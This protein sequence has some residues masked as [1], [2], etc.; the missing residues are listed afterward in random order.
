MVS[1]MHQLIARFPSSFSV[2]QC[3]ERTGNMH[4]FCGPDYGPN[5]TT[6]SPVCYCT[7]NGGHITEGGVTEAHF[8]YGPNG[9]G[10][11]TA[12]YYVNSVFITVTLAF[13]IFVMVYALYGV[14]V[15]V[16][17]RRTCSRNIT[18]TT[19]AWNTLAAVAVVV[20]E[21]SVFVGSVVMNS[22][23]PAFAFELPVAVPLTLI[24][25]TFVR[26]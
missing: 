20:M 5:K 4:T 6:K 24:C 2:F 1:S 23:Y 13:V 11:P 21:I 25:S 19:L 22:A 7:L 14:Y 10:T 17:V 15:A 9:C 16:A 26:Y 12:L 8:V 3:A 18:N